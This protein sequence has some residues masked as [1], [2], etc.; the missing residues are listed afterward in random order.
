MVG[1]DDTLGVEEGHPHLLGPCCTDH[2][3]DR[4]GG[5]LWQ[6]MPGLL[7]GLWCVERHCS[8]LS[9]VYNIVHIVMEQRRTIIA[10]KS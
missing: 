4:A 3:L 7:F 10:K 2:G 1:V 6:P 5:A 8:D 9:M